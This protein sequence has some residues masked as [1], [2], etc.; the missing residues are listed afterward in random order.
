MS[1]T[2]TDNGYRYYEGEWLFICQSCKKNPGIV[3]EYGLNDY[4]KISGSS[5]N[6][7]GLHSSEYC[8]NCGD[9]LVW[10]GYGANSPVTDKL[11]DLLKDGHFMASTVILSAIIENS[12]RDLLWAVLSDRGMETKT[13]DEVAELNLGRIEMI[14]IISTISGL[15]INDI[16]F[17]TRNLVAHGKGFT[18]EE[19]EYK[20]KLKNQINN[21]EQWVSTIVSDVELN[22][23]CPNE[24]QRWL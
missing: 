18:L 10:A 15:K 13:S 6:N 21:I 5:L 2:K 12:I 17:S 3:F 11:I 7:C 20:S 8:K 23:Y 4:D 22:N 14:K 19:K 9:P 24:T 1:K 16:S